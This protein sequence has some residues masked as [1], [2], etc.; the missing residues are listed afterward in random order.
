MYAISSARLALVVI[1]SARMNYFINNLISINL[2]V[3]Q[4]LI[5]EQ[6]VARCLHLK[7]SYSYRQDNK[8]SRQYSFLNLQ[9]DI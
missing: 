9:L 4:L 7:R 8:V 3:K 6:S 2:S 1:Q 5:S